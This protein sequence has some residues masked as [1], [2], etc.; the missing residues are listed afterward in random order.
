ILNLDNTDSIRCKELEAAGFL[1]VDCR[2]TQ[3]KLGHAFKIYNN[4]CPKYLSTHFLKLNENEARIATRAK[5]YNFHV[6]K[7]NPN[8]FVFST[9]K[10]WNDL[11]NEIKD[12]KVE[13]IFKN[14]VKV[15]LGKKAK[16]EEEKYKVHKDTKV[17]TIF[18][19]EVK[20]FLGK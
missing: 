17:E 1:N 18:K 6:P 8:T 16:K 9:I 12:T 5:A 11:D 13:T 20:V 7:I 19:N 4:T 3:L 15:F 2:V 10:D 14:K